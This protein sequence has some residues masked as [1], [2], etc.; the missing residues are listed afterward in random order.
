MKKS[1][2]V[3]AIAALGFALLGTVACGGGEK[4]EPAPAEA[5]KVVEEKPTAAP[6]APAAPATDAA[7]PATGAPAAD[8]AAPAAPA[9][10]APAAPAA[11]AA[12]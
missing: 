9:T 1:I 2:S 4:K 12:K 6:E 5:P 11:P 10:G 8:A 7:A 3:L